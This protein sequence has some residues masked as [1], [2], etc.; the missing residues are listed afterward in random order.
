MV[1]PA[2]S[3]AALSVMYSACVSTF[4]IRPRLSMTYCPSTIAGTPRPL[5]TPKPN[6]VRYANQ[7]QYHAT[8]G[9]PTRHAPRELPE[10][11]RLYRRRVFKGVHRDKKH[12]PSKEKG[13]KTR[14]KRVHQRS[15]KAPD[16]SEGA[17]SKTASR[18]EGQ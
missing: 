6:K 16:V 2:L 18:E 1:A 7:R 14:E 15:R 10:E 4:R 9:G 13:E 17:H 5:W 3:P 8:R 12:D 11:A